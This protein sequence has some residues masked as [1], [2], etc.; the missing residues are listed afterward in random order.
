MQSTFLAKQKSMTSSILRMLILSL[1]S[2]ETPPGVLHLA[3]G[4]PAWERHEPMGASPE[5]SHEDDQRAEAC[6]ENLR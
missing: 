3:L 5:E 2:S 6:E 4:F 1:C